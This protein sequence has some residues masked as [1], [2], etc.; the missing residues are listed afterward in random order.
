MQFPYVKQLHDKLK[1]ARAVLG[2]VIPKGDEADQILQPV[3][4]SPAELG[5]R[6]S[7]KICLSEDDFGRQT[8]GLYER[9][10][11]RVVAIPG[12][13]VHHPAINQLIA[14]LTGGRTPMPAPFYNHARR[15]FQQ[16]RL[17]FLTVR[18]CPE[19]D[20]FG[21]V[22][23]HT[24]VP[25]AE[26]RRWAESHAAPNLSIYEAPLV[27]DD[28]D[29][30]LTDKAT[31]LAGPRDLPFTIG[32]KTYQLSPLAFFQANF[33]LT[34][35]FVE[36]VIAGAFGRTLLDL[37]GGFGAYGLAAA[38]HFQKVYLVDANRHATAAA[39]SALAAF[40][41]ANVV[42]VRVPVE[43]FLERGLNTAER[44]QVTHAIVNPPRG[45][46]SSKVRNLL[47]SGRLPRLSSLTY[48]SCNIE[49]LRRD[50]THL[51]KAGGF[52]VKSMVPFDMF[53]QTDHL[54]MVVKLVASA[55]KPARP[56]AHKSGKASARKPAKSRPR[57]ESPR[58]PRR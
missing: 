31:H 20:A 43:V 27:K 4:P 45:G 40:N 35:R 24:G 48:V 37:Y 17:K 51:T 12:C 5:Y 55:R 47:S 3:T 10:T 21:I 49:T 1:T 58:P 23:S 44:H 16:G 11:K 53:P 46:L 9:G 34:A 2:P 32:D 15:G 39:E 52:E 26:L 6:T 54:E 57:R 29:L 50:L 28:D 36:H 18:Y 22:L 33:S 38:K 19:T 13:P 30:I 7:T 14:K 56:S 8:I 42:P 41:V 25:E